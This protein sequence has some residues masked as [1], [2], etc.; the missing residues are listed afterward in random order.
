[1]TERTPAE[2]EF[3][4]ENI[5]ARRFSPAARTMPVQETLDQYNEANALEPGDEEFLVHPD[6]ELSAITTHGGATIPGYALKSN[7]AA[8]VANGNVD[9]ARGT[10]RISRHL[11]ASLGL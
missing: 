4:E 5:A 8:K 3:I 2:H 10:D 7:P 6:L 1:M 11:G 9:L